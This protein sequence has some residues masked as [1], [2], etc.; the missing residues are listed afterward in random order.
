MGIV[1]PMPTR[2]DV[3]NRPLVAVALFLIVTLGLTG[4]WLNGGSAFY[5][6]LFREVGGPLY[7]LFGVHD[8]SVRPRLRYANTIP[9]AGL[10]VATPGLDWLRKLRILGLGCGILFLSHLL[11]NLSATSANGY[12]LSALARLGADLSPFVLWA[13]LCRRVLKPGIEALLRGSLSD[14]D[15]PFPKRSADPLAEAERATAKLSPPSE[16]PA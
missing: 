14:P 13:L 1:P 2:S 12:Q 11:L 15:A 10:V 6:K 4:L 8:I 5:G 7:D 16:P 9:F 3:P